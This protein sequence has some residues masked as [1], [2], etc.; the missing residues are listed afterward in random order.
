MRRIALFVVA[1]LMIVAFTTTSTPS[2]AEDA[3]CT[4]AAL[5]KMVGEDFTALGKELETIPKTGAGGIYTIM[6]SISNTRIKYEDMKTPSD[7]PCA[8][9]VLETIIFLSN[10]Q[11]YA[12]VELADKLGLD[13]AMV[14]ENREFV[15]KRLEA[16]SKIVLALIPETK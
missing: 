6:V 10:V 13:K 3:K 8:F 16:Q 11:D 9:L 1:L 7:L 14:A 12:V 5:L 2:R 4:D 15:A